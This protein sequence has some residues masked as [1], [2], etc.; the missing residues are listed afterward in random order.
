MRGFVR[1]S[2][3]N[4]HH[5]SSGRAEERGE[6]LVGGAEERGKGLSDDASVTSS[7]VGEAWKRHNNRNKKEK[8]RRT[9]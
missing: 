1:K 3:A 2:D 5:S 9:T 4:H 7:V 6:G 8:T